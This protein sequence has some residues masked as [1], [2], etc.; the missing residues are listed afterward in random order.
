MSLLSTLGLIPGAGAVQP[1]V[2]AAIAK[3][4]N[5]LMQQFC[6]EVAH[7]LRRHE[8]RIGHVE[9]QSFVA[10]GQAAA[11]LNNALSIAGKT[12]SREK[13]QLLANALISAASAPPEDESLLPLFWSL[14]ERHSALDAKLLHFFS[15]PINLAIRAG[16]E[17]KTYPNEAEALFHVIPELRYG[18]LVEEEDGYMVV[19]PT[20]EDEDDEE[21]WDEPE[22]DVTK[23]PEPYFLLWYSMHR[24]LDDQLIDL[25]DHETIREKLL[26]MAEAEMSMGD[27]KRGADGLFPGVPYESVTELG[28]R[29]LAFLMT[30]DADRL[31]ATRP[32]M[33]PVHVRAANAA[34]QFGTSE[35]IAAY[36][37]ADA[38]AAWASLGLAEG[39]PD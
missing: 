18:T 31:D 16:Y 5:A 15:D 19:R 28:A 14:V 22:H 2:E 4:R 26:F 34:P 39:D 32:D 10:Q 36:P 12:A 35:R 20:G 24:L 29:Y 3:G 17:F 25:G 30:P 37:G 27:S 6:E 1:W 23:A 9:F 8:H 21:R 33:R 7:A 13:H 38:S 11:A